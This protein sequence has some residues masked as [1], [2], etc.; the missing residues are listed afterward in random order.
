MFILIDTKVE[1]FWSLYSW[2]VHPS[3][4]TGHCDYHLFKDGIK[5]MWEVAIVFI[6]FLDYIVY[7]ALSGYNNW[8]CC[9]KSYSFMF[10]LI[11]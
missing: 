5:P 2:L 9:N 4:L 7:T 10:R 6:E 1:Q 3:E 11:L 8:S